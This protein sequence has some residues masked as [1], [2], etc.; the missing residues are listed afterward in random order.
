LSLE[1]TEQALQR[2][3][4]LISADKGYDWREF[5]R[6]LRQVNKLLGAGPDG[7]AINLFSGHLDNQVALTANSY[8]STAGN[9]SVAGSTISVDD[10][11]SMALSIVQGAGERSTKDPDD[12]LTLYWAGV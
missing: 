1:K 7:D 11:M 12:I 4:R 5:D 8:I 6:W 10:A 9:T 3:P 2:P